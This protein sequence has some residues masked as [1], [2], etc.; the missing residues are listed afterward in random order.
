MYFIFANVI[1]LS[2]C[3]SNI[4]KPEGKDFVHLLECHNVN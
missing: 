3:N 4:Q 2:W 1:S